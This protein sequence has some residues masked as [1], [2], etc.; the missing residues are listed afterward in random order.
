VS[1]GNEIGLVCE[2]QWVAGVLL[3][4]WIEGGRRWRQLST[5]SRSYGGAPAGRRAREEEKEVKWA[6][7]SAKV[8]LWGA[9]G[10][11]SS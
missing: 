6:C 4:P 10:R 1:A 2:L 7:V 8:N 11:A 3:E 9:P 5:A